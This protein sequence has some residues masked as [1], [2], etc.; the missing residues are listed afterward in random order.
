MSATLSKSEQK[1][2]ICFFK[3]PVQFHDKTVQAAQ[4][5]STC[6]LDS[7]TAAA[8]AVGVFD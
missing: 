4:P 8:A 6:Q 7:T 5:A 1:L 3:E 2:E